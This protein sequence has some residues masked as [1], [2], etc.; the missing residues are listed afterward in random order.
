MLLIN[1]RNYIIISGGAP[2]LKTKIEK[3]SEERVEDRKISERSY[4]LLGIRE[5][6]G[7]IVIELI[8][9]NEKIGTIHI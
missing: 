5:G 9:G 7:T 2:D 3:K 8:S 1:C 6:S 4:E